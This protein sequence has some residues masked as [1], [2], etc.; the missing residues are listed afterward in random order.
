MSSAQQRLWFLDRFDPGSAT[1]VIPVAVRLHGALDLAAL[2]RAFNL[3]TERHESLR[4]VF[5]DVDGQPSQ[6][7]MPPEPRT[8][9]VEPTTLATQDDGARLVAEEAARGYL[10]RPAA[11]ARVCSRSV[12]LA[13]RSLPLPCRRYRDLACVV[14]SR[15]LPAGRSSSSKPCRSCPVSNRLRRR[16]RPS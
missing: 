14:S 12:C 9:H 4:T 1:Y 8:L 10:G 15:S 5:T 7:I 16:C 11:T 6:V 3:L 13:S 2:E